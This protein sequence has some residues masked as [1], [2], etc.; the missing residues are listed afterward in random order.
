MATLTGTGASDSLIGGPADDVLIGMGA[1]DTDHPDYLSGGGGG[2]EYRLIKETLAV[3]AYVIEDGGTDGATD[4][5]TGAGALVQSASLGYV[6]WATALRIGDDLVLHLPHKP[7]EFRKPA[8]PAFDIEIRGQFSGTGVETIDAGGKLWQIASGSIGT[9]LADIVA[10]GNRADLLEGLGGDDYLCGNGGADTLLL[11]DGFDTA[12]GGKGADRIDGGADDDRIDAGAGRDSVDGGPGDDYILTGDGRDAADGGDGDDFLYGGK[13][14]DQLDG[15]PGRDL[16]AGGPGNDLVIGG[17]GGD[18]YRIDAPAGADRIVERGGGEAVPAPDRIELIGFYGSSAG[19]E[20]ALARLAFLRAG[21]DMRMVAD[22]GDYV[23]TVRKMFAANEAR[24]FIEELRLSAGYQTPLD[25]RILAADHHAIGDDRT[26]PELNEALFGDDRG[27]AIFGGS[28][29][30]L[31]WTGDGADV[32]IYK[33]NDP[34]VPFG[35]SY[36][37]SRDIVADFDPAHDRLD[38]TEIPGVGFA[39]LEIGADAEG[40]A[41]IFWDSGSLDV[42]DILIELRGVTAAEVTADLFSFA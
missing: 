38:F 10:G 7:G 37:V 2:D 21:D 40:D 18:V 14:R 31:I 19:P 26:A 4:R 6:G 11:G 20:A 33:E 24:F 27:N 41:L 42:A 30:N 32:L 9:A 3:H 8:R 23:L 15:G 1:P 29:L 12:F 5:I 35:I 28:G 34:R 13:G 16:L 22:G 25:F 39:D 36:P 17:P